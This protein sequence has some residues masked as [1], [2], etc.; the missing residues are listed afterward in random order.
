VACLDGESK[1]IDPNANGILHVRLARDLKTDKKK[2]RKINQRWKWTKQPCNGWW[3]SLSKQLS[4]RRTWHSTLGRGKLKA[5]AL[6]SATGKGLADCGA[7]FGAM[8]IVN[9]ELSPA[10]RQVEAALA[11]ENAEAKTGDLARLQHACAVLDE[12]TGQWRNC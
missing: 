10:L 6:F 7:E 3:K 5:N 8:K 9:K 12:A 2:I 1:L 4:F 11:T